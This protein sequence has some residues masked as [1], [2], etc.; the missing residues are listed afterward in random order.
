MKDPLALWDGPFPYDVF[1]DAGISPKSTHA[2]VK[3]V[4]YALMRNN[5]FTQEAQAA[6]NELRL[7]DRRLFVDLFV[8]PEAAPHTGGDR[9]RR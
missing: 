2:E 6:W 3:N 7:L 4:T 9:D 5:Q 1:A 8:Y